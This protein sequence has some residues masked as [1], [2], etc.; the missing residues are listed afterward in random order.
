MFPR[1][2]AMSGVEVKNDGIFHMK[3]RARRDVVGRAERAV[4]VGGKGKLFDFPPRSL[5]GCEMR[6]FSVCLL[7]PAKQ[8]REMRKKCRRKQSR[9]CHRW[10]ISTC[11]LIDYFFHCECISGCG[12]YCS[13]SGAISIHRRARKNERNFQFAGRQN[14]SSPRTPWRA[15]SHPFADVFS[16]I[17]KNEETKKLIKSDI[18]KRGVIVLWWIKLISCSRT[19]RWLRVREKRGDVAFLGL[20]WVE[21]EGKDSFKSIICCCFCPS[22][23]GKRDGRKASSSSAGETSEFFAQLFIRPFVSAL[24]SINHTPAGQE[25]KR[26]DSTSLLG[27]RSRAGAFP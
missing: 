21:W 7:S 13:I 1:L 23:E 9:S 22:T 24:P 2:N 14:E 10:N 19:P 4:C 20:A 6:N 15:F 3:V 17:M 25:R 8:Q 12:A 27:S 18:R 11:R 16:V 26:G 5:H